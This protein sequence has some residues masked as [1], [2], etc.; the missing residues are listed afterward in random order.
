MLI[1]LK[2]LAWCA[3]GLVVLWVLALLA[4]PALVK[5]QVPLRLGQA[6]GRTV[7]L[8]SVSFKPWSLDLTLNDVVV[9]GQPEA[10]MPLMKVKRLRLNASVSSL[11]RRSAVM[12]ALDVDGLEL[13]VARTSEGHYDID[14]LIARFTPDPTVVAAKPSEPMR[15]A[16]YNLQVRDAQFR[17]DDRPESQVHHVKALEL[18]LPLLSNFPSDVEVTVQPHLRFKLGETLF[19]SGAQATP[20]AVNK[21]GSLSLNVSGLNLAPLRGYLPASVPVHFTQ[22]QVSTKLNLQFSVPQKGG[23]SVSLKGLVD[24]E[25]LNLQDAQGH[26]LAEV[27]S[28]S[29][30]LQNVQPLAKKV[31]LEALQIDGL[32]LHVARDGAGRLNLLQLAGTRP[33]AHNEKPI[34]WG[35]SLESFELKNSQVLW[36]D[37]LVKPAAAVQLAVLSLSAEKLH[38]PLKEPLDVE[39]KGQLQTQGSQPQVLGDF[40]VSGPVGEHGLKLKFG[41]QALS[42]QAFSPYVAQVMTPSVQGQLSANGLLEWSGVRNA[43]KFNLGLEHATLDALKVSESP[44]HVS[45]AK[46]LRVTDTHLDFL[47]RTARLGSVK[48]VQP[49]LMMDRDAKGRLNLQRWMQTADQASAP[50]HTTQAATQSPWRI[51]LK[52]FSIESGRLQF[53]DVLPQPLHASVADLNLSVRG[54][55]WPGERSAPPSQVH[56]SARL[57]PTR[58]SPGAPLSGKLDF[59]GK[60]GLAPFLVDGTLQAERLPVHLGTPYVADKF[61]LSLVRAE[62]GYRGTVAIAQL[63]KGLEVAAAGNALLT[64]VH[65]A[66]KSASADHDKLLSWKSLTLNGVKLALKPQQRPQLE[67]TDAELSDFYSR[68]VITEQGRFNLQDAGPAPE[69]AVVDVEPNAPEAAASTPDP[70]ASAPVLEAATDAPLPIDLKLGITKLSRGRIDFTD[71]FVRPNYSAALT[72]LKGQMGAFSSNNRDMAALELQGK[73]EG[74]AQLTINGKINPLV[75]PLALDIN[76]RATDLDLAPFSTYAGKYAGYAIDSGKLSMDVAYKISPEGQL[77]AKNKIVLK[78]LTFGDKIESKEATKLPVRFAVSLLKDRHGVI[79]VNLPI[80]G[81]INDPKFSMGG[82]IWKAVVNLLGKA[83]TSP[84][85]LLTGGAGDELSVVEFEPGTARA[86]AAASASLDKVAKALV[87]RTGLK[88]SVVGT[89]NAELERDA[90]VQASVEEKILVL[91]KRAP[92]AQELA[93]EE[94]DAA[95]EPEAPQSAAPELGLDER[96]KWLRKIYDGTKISN[97]PRNAFG[98]V[99]NISESE[100]MALIKANTAVSSEAMH[101][102]AQRRGV[103]VRDALIAKGVPSER[104]YLAAP[105]VI[106]AADANNKPSVQLSVSSH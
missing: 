30:G 66:E 93:P 75:K 102:M 51:G 32:R 78:Q 39:L 92:L 31:A 42:L 18:A 28:L 76:A 82:V 59:K 48:M 34:A 54:F 46:Q 86:P 58:R 103:A 97:K 41:L 69:A 4:V 64:N 8:G 68:L 90:F 104:V 91:A 22:G 44:T 71:R 37:A 45:G 11:L 94:D 6:L 19:D 99:K 40:Q 49:V 106:E 9:A 17:F 62:A 100:M 84:F 96:L 43:L 55:E 53:A 2:R 1:W 27:K 7:M 85:S 101:D 81:S 57:G 38:W 12:E 72:E 14:D 29:L 61:K 20:F 67:M 47:A 5:W 89:F 63:P 80:S 98:L 88:V 83:I 35:V 60:L 77:D 52:D 33:E 26:A 79:D 36:N 16:L 70:G 95:S 87:D 105:K 23:V 74:T 3:V 56:L 13:H 25:N 15:F 50:T 24:V 21:A 65:V 73:L 10:P